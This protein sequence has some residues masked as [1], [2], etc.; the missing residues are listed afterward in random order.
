MNRKDFIK[1]FGWITIVGLLFPFTAARVFKNY[2]RE[3]WCNYPS[4][5]LYQKSIREILI[6]LLDQQ[7]INWLK[8]Q[9]AIDKYEQKTISEINR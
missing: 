7:Q 8:L 3:K 4:R 1:S 2:S 5:M 9:N 6:P